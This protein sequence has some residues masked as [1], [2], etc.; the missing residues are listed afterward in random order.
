MSRED[1][2][3]GLARRADAGFGL[4]EVIVAMIVLSVGVLSVASVLT[5]SVAMQTIAA[6]RES[7]LSI[8][9]T[10][11]EQIRATVPALVVPQAAV[12]V[13]E[14]GVPTVGGVFSRQVTVT[15]VSGNINE[16]TVIVT[17]PRVSPVRL[18]VWIYDSSI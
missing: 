16:V 4:I 17:A 5:Q 11:M 10:E 3:E 12:A 14:S 2:I 15:T 8:A 13:N 7:A 9:Q 18:V 6:Q 1:R